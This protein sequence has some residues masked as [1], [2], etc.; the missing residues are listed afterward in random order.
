MTSNKKLTV[1]D[2]CA[3]D[4]ITV[5]HVYEDGVFYLYFDSAADGGKLF[6]LELDLDDTRK[7]SAFLAKISE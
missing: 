3:G 7:L 5:R 2:Q 1:T 4:R 6:A